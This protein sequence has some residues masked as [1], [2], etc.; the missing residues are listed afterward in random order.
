MYISE[1]KVDKPK[2]I[3]RSND[4]DED[5]DEYTAHRAN[6]RGRKKKR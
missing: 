4:E 2:T 1:E 3:D 6:P 5:D